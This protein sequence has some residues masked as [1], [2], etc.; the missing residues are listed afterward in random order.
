LL[1]GCLAEAGVVKSMLQIVSGFQPDVDGM[2]DFCR[3]LGDALWAKEQVCSHFLVYRQPKWPLDTAT[4]FPNTISYPTERTPAALLAHIAELQA[5]YAFDS[6]LLHYGPYAYTSNG[7]PTP[8]VEAIEE[9]VK[10]TEVLIFFHETYAS[11][12]PWKRAF[13]TKREQKN[14]LGRLMHCAKVA[15]TSNEKYVGML[16]DLDTV[17]RELVKAPVISNIGEPEGLRPLKNRS[18]QLVVFGQLANR[19]RLYKEHRKR[20]ES[21][22]QMLRIEKIVDVGSGDS[23]YIPQAVLDAGVRRAGFMSD[24]ALSDLLADSVA[25]VI[26]YWPDVWEKSG[27]MA[28]YEAHGV[29][30]ILVPM[31]KRR[32][33][34][35]AYVPYVEAED[36]VRLAGGEDSVSNENL[37]GI[38]NAAHAYYVENQS[39]NRCAEVIARYAI[40]RES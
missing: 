23:P 18:R 28:A 7:R 38:V 2:G 32:L 8:F 29:V 40:H 20:L 15:F 25:G 11:R 31:E 17:G 22:C 6:V 26:C 39:V 36:L 33:P 1:E 30:P 5:S 3:R 35:P 14:A 12:P 10:T 37:Q 21:I 34:K 24:E 4:I 27:V 13:W 9:L 16:Q 19:V